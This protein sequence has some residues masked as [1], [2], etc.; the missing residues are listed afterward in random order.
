MNQALLKSFLFDRQQPDYR[1]RQ[2]IRNYYSGRFKSFSDMTDLPKDLRNELE[3][4]LP[5]LSLQ[6][7]KIQ[8][9]G[10]TQKALLQLSDNQTIESV[11]MDYG[12]WLTA[13]VSSQVGCPL[14]CKF[15]AT[16]KMGFVRN[17]TTEEI[18]D[19]IIFWKQQISLPCQGEV[20]PP[21]RDRRGFRVVFMGMGEPFL[22]WDNLLAA[23]KIINSPSALNI[24]ARKISVSTAGIV[25]KIK[26]FADLNTEINLA[27]SLHSL[28]QKVRQSIM[29]MALQY[30]LDQLKSA[31]LYYVNRTH[32]QLFF[33]YSLIRGVND[34]PADLNLLIPFLSSHRLFFLNLIPLNSVT[35]GLSPSSS[36]TTNSFTSQLQRHHLNFSLRHSFGQ[37]ISAACGQLATSA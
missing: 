1:L 26:E 21:R 7:Q 16:G 15:C 5:F 28:D 12:D 13:C 24:G 31:C 35:C 33:E 32:R 18:I 27:V 37:D 30:P 6:P 22:N 4:R 23:L 8:V 25:P 19:Q 14:N 29:P 34:R 20:V 10:Q 11:L 9:V 36:S 3:H 2:I 17:L